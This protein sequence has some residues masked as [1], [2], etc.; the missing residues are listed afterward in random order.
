MVAVRHR[1]GRRAL[2]QDEIAAHQAG[3]ATCRSRWRSASP[4]ASCPGRIRHVPLPSHPE[5]REPLRISAPSPNSASVV[6]SGDAGGFLESG[7]HRSCRRGCRPRRRGGR[8]RGA[9]PPASTDRSRRWIST[10]PRAL[11]GASFRSTMSSLA[12]SVGIEAE[13]DPAHELFVRTR[14]AERSC[15]SARPRG[16]RCEAAPRAPRR[17]EAES[18]TVTR[19]AW[20][21]TRIRPLLVTLPSH[22]TIDTQS[23]Q[24]SQRKA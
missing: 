14:G 9:D 10:S 2:V 4:C 5:Q 19:R 18:R 1:R 16:A 22:S 15:R 11:R 21:I 13:V 8:C 23:S 17:A 12:G 3:D 6:G 24:S 7:E 20:T